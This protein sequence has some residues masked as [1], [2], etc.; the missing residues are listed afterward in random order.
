M[1]SWSKM[2]FGELAY[3]VLRLGLK[4]EKTPYMPAILMC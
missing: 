3:K 4:S 2:S 1:I